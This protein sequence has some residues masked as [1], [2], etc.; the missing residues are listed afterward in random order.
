MI[1]NIVTSTIDPAT[2]Q[3]VRSHPL[4]QGM[5]EEELRNILPNFRFFELRSNYVLIQEGQNSDDLFLVLKGT[6]AVTKRT[7]DQLEEEITRNIGD[8]FTIAQ[9][10]GGDST[11]ELSFIKGTLRSATVKTITPVALLGLDRVGLRKL[12]TEFPAT[13]N[14]FMK[15]M[16]S[17]VGER[18]MQT[19]SNQVH[20]LKVELDHSIL[21]SKSNLFFSYI[22]GLLCV[23]NLTIHLITNLY[24]DGE[25]GSLISAAMIIAFGVV[26][27][28]MIRQ[29][30]LPIKIFGLTTVNWKAALGESM[31]WTT[32]IISAMIAV[33]WILITNV[34]RYSELPLFDFDPSNQRYLAFN[35][36][37]YGLHSPIQEFIARGVLQGS[38]QHFFT[39]RNV[40]FRAILVSNA[41]FSA[42]HV[43]L[44][45]GMLALVVFVPGLFWGWLYSRHPNLIGVSVSHIL[46]GW[47][48]L[49]LLN[50]ESLF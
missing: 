2:W 23:Y 39:G 19:S 13:S 10:T 8:R 7:E 26:L 6:L 15:N 34:E 5:S 20:A 11:G 31:L 41:L 1:Q 24:L 45:G 44:L 46:I 28:L 14:T 17:Y 50:L 49:F 37:V 3:L 18:L 29:S 21:A 47:A 25:M 42:T 9:I 32:V 48:G 36:I 12:E 33:K 22:I 43:H 30:R 16:L 40:T 27:T 38:L 35:F 4:F